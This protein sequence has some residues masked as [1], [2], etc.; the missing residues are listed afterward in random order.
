[1]KFKKDNLNDMTTA[2]LSKKKKSTLFI[3]GLLIGALIVSFM[4]TILHT[5][6]KGFSLLLVVPFTSFP[7]LVMLFIQLRY[8]NKELKSRKLK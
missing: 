7:I 1:M 3:T 4:I 6:N 2:D 5:F 8:I